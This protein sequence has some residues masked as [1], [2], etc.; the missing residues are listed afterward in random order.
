LITAE[1]EVAADVEVRGIIQLLYA[2]FTAKSPR[3]FAFD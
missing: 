2:D 1:V 3:V